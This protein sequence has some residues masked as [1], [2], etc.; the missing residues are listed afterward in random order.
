VSG[1]GWEPPDRGAGATAGHARFLNRGLP[2][3]IEGVA[4]PDSAATAAQ[5]GADDR[6]DPEQPGDRLDQGSDA[7]AA[8]LRPGAAG[9]TGEP[10]SSEAGTVGGGIGTGDAGSGTGIGAA[11]ATQ[12]GAAAADR[13]PGRIQPSGVE[14][15]RPYPQLLRGPEHRWWRP[16]VG[17]GVLLGSIALLVIAFG[18]F[19]DLIHLLAG[20]GSPATGSVPSPVDGTGGVTP[21][22]LLGLNLSVAAF[23]PLALLAVLAGHRWPPGFLSSVTGRLRR[24]WLLRCLATCILVLGPLALVLSLLGGVLRSSHGPHPVLIMVVVLLTTPLQ[25]AGEEYLFRGWLNQAVGS[26]F[27]RPLVACVVGALVSSTLFAIAHGSQDGWLFADRWL[28]GLLAAVLVWR[29]GGLEVSIAL[30]T[31]FNVVAWAQAVGFGS[32][33]DAVNSSRMSPLSFAL[34]MAQVLIVASVLARLAGR[35]N[36][37]RLYRPGSVTDE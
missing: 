11:Q 26:L 27:G 14:Q 15:P 25:A 6:P 34:D 32:L 10:G 9:V 19:V 13:D 22:D 7:T 5:P 1:I 30:H 31:V 35:E 28:F 20:G 23:L 36:P 12:P 16:L 18:L 21:L 4:G 8:E 33:S 3:F 29:T 24:R 2:P 37:I 17:L